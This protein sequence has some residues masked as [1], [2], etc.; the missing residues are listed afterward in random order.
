MTRPRRSRIW[1]DKPWSGSRRCPAC[2]RQPR[3]VAHGG[4]GWAYVTHRFFDV[5]KV[6]VVRGRGFTERDAAGTPGV[7]IINEAFARKYWPRESP[8]GQRLIIGPGM[9]P[10]FAEPA[11]EIIGVVA[12]ARDAGLNSDPQP[13]MFVPLPQVRDAVMVLNNR[14][15]PL[16]WVVRTNVGPFSVSA[17]VQRVFQDLADLP[18]GHIRSMDQVV[19]QSTARD[20]FNTLLLVVFA[21]VAILL[22]SI[23]LYGLMAYTVEQRTL[24][25][26]IRLALGAD[27][28]ALRNMIVGQA[29]ALAVAG[30]VLGLGAAYGLTR[31]MVTMLYDVKPTDPVVFGSV[32]ILLGAVAFFAS[33][34]PARRAVR[35]D[36]VVA[37]RYE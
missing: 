17:P 19:V 24:E 2:G 33:Y 27:A 12:D 3:A 31:L 20:Q 11:R 7:V 28:W 10:A 4:A 36:P 13:E 5:F 30:I 35:I 23:G 29:M 37:L 18:V 32:A 9:G 14:F 15:L 26:G 34:L 21:L 1:R 8:L 22:A 6:P 16:T 25:F